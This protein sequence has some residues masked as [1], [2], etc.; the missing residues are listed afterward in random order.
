MKKKRIISLIAVKKMI[1]LRVAKK[2]SLKVKKMYLSLK[3][4][5]KLPIIMELVQP[6]Q[7][8]RKRI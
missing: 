8:P 3:N 5:L 6:S 4:K 2:M 1:S 7:L